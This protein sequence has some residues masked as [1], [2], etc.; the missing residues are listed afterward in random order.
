VARLRVVGQCS[1][2]RRV[3]RL[4]LGGRPVR[5]VAVSVAVP[6]PAAVRLRVERRL[7]RPLL[8]P[9]DDLEAKAR[10]ETLLG[11]ELDAELLGE[12][13]RERRSRDE[14]ALDEDLAEPAVVRALLCKRELELLV[15]QETLV[16]EKEA[17][18]APG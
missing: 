1:K 2:R 8:V 17:Q 13:V 16:D 6:V 7:D 10:A 9:A 14:A 12:D 11:R 4:G 15:R 5:G 18:G 3:V